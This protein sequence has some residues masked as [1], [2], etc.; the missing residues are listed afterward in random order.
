MNSDE[1]Q[2]SYITEQRTPSFIADETMGEQFA[3]M[4]KDQLSIGVPL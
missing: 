4:R 3:A 2:P 1:W